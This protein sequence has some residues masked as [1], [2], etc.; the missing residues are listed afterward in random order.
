[1]HLK[2][3]SLMILVAALAAA[4]TLVLAEKTG[5]QAVVVE[6][7][8]PTGAGIGQA[9]EIRG[10]VTAIDKVKRT[11]TVKGPRGKTKTLTVGKEARNFDQVKVGDMVT[12]TYMEALTVSLEKAAG[13]K[14][15]TSV[16]EELKRA[17][18]GEKPGGQLTTQTTVVG[19]V[20]A[21][22]AKT[23]MVTVRGP[24]GNEVD[25]KVQDPAKLKNL[26]KGDL[27]K[28]TYTEALAISVTEQAKPAAMPK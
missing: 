25:L 2:S 28:A 1:M 19:T 17:E 8:G 20:T 26:K 4:P 22:D 5:A 9:V 16:T 12:L 7:K 24:E 11:V 13:A 15:G 6:A 10:T 3:K 21:V 23:H 18:P 27:V 14:P